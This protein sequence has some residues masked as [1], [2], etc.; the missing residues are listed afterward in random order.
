MKPYLRLVIAVFLF[1]GLASLPA[2][3]DTISNFSVN[4]TFDTGAVLSGLLTIDTTNGTVTAAALD[5]SAGTTNC[6]L[7]SCS[8]QDFDSIAGQFGSAALFL[9]NPTDDA[10]LGLFFPSTDFVAYKGGSTLGGFV[11]LS[12]FKGAVLEAGTLRAPE[13]ASFLVLLTGLAI[14]ALVARNKLTGKAAEFS[15]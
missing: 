14:L 11:N 3:A 12:D 5:V 15:S 10:L 6:V 9:A 1:S 2:R 7:E 13:P 8:A 4:G